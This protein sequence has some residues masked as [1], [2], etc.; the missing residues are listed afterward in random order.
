MVNEGKLK[1]R[2]KK[3]SSDEASELDGFDWNQGLMVHTMPME[4]FINPIP[5][6]NQIMKEDGSISD[7]SN[8]KHP[9]T[10]SMVPFLKLCIPNNDYTD[11]LNESKEAIKELGLVPSFYELLRTITTF[12][13]LGTNLETAKNGVIINL[14]SIY[15][16]DA[17]EFHNFRLMFENKYKQIQAKAEAWEKSMI[18]KQEELNIK[19]STMSFT[20]HHAILINR[21]KD[22]NEQELEKE[23]VFAEY[24]YMAVIFNKI[25]RNSDNLKMKFLKECLDEFLATVI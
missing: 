4:S 10:D 8:Q 13:S 15:S 25:I 9:T 11:F 6:D 16:S 3:L 22:M 12:E 1:P 2:L 24:Y 19:A 23:L 18:T 21:V 5:M 14:R 17:F 7:V 20:E